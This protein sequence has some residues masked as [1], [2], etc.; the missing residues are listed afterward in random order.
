M[1]YIQWAWL[2]GSW[3]EG[4]RG[5]GYSETNMMPGMGSVVRFRPPA[6]SG[7]S[8]SPVSKKGSVGGTHQCKAFEVKREQ[9]INFR[10]MQIQTTERLC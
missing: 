5:G 8:Y 1:L 6:A 2:E 4:V 7:P 9:T 3:P 10:K